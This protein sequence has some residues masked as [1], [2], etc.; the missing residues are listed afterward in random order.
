MAPLTLP[1]AKP[2]DIYNLCLKPI[3]LSHIR[4]YRDHGGSTPRYAGCSMGPINCMRERGTHCQGADT[5]LLFFRQ[6][7]RASL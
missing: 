4:I 1:V 7:E 2:V 3:L 6:L 5:V